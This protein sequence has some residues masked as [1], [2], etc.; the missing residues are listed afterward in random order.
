MQVSTSIKERVTA[1]LKE[2]IDIAKRAYGVDITFPTVVYKKRGTTAGTASYTRWVLDFNPILLNENVDDF[3]SRTVPHELAHLITDKVFPEAH[4]TSVTFTRRGQIKRSKREVHGNA[5]QSVMRVLGADPKRCHS[6]D[7]ANARV[8]K[9]TT[10]Y[11]YRCD[12]CNGIVEC[13]PKVHA[14]LQRG[15]NYRHRSCGGSKL[16]PVGSI[17]RSNVPVAA[18]P[19]N[20]PVT[21]PVSYGTSKLD[22]CKQIYTSNRGV[23]RQTMIGMFVS[24]AGCTPAGAGTYYNTCMKTC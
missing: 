21:P 12:K 7:V 11:Q 1:K 24:M 16:V 23:S 6:Y 18:T 19:V 10:K 4:N 5:W 2:G 17:V 15:K 8:K 20:K 9:T 14:N 3:I 13:G 22:K